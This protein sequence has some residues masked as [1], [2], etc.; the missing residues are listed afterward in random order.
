MIRHAGPD[1]PD[2]RVGVGPGRR[3]R[4][5]RHAAG[6]VGALAVAV[7]AAPFGAALMVG[8][9]GSKRPAAGARA[10]LRR[11][12]GMSAV[13]GRADGEGLVAE[14]AGFLSEGL[15]HGVGARG[16]T[17]DWTTGLNRGTTAAIG[18]IC[19]SSGRSRGSRWGAPG[20]H[21]TSES[22]L[23][24]IRTPCRPPAPGPWTPPLPKDA[25]NAPSGSLENREERGFPQRPQPRSSSSSSRSTRRD[26]CP[27]P[28]HRRASRI[29]HHDQC[30]VMTSGAR[31]D[32]RRSGLRVSCACHNQS[33]AR[34]L[35]REESALNRGVRRPSGSSFRRADSL[36]CRSAST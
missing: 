24:A 6:A 19:R 23:Y 20:P 18:S 29:C 3:G 1:T 25:K 26:R 33:P 5:T 36:S 11:A 35:S 34:K 21:P 30:R 14:S 12:V 10:T 27:G 17:S 16:A 28:A 2:G 15:V 13:A 4:V 7:V 9:G 8:S 32:R 31:R 22:A